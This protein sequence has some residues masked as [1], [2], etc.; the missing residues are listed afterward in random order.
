MQK[1]KQ[2]K[3]GHRETQL[4]EYGE[5]VSNESGTNQYVYSG[6]AQLGNHQKQKNQVINLT[7]LFQIQP[8]P[9][10]I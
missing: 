4:K 8:K 5:N 2:P 7:T 1:N 9:T 6:G 3:M 10:R